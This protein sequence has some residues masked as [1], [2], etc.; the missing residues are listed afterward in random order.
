MESQAAHHVEVDLQDGALARLGCVRVADH[1]ER[2]DGGDLP[3]GEHPVHVV[4]GHDDEHR[5]K[6]QEHEGRE[7]VTAVV[8]LAAGGAGRLVLV[9]L[10][11]LH[12][13]QGVHAD[14]AAH[15]AH[16]EHHDHGEVIHVE[17][18]LE[19]V[20]GRR[21]QRSAPD[22]EEELHHGEREHGGVAER[23]GI[24]EHHAAKQQVNAHGHKITSQGQVARDGQVRWRVEKRGRERDRRGG[25]CHSRR[26]DDAIAR[27]VLPNKQQDERH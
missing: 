27:R 24:A 20:L 21:G 7:L 19:D 6:E 8:D 12:V 18:L 17:R 25:G 16:D 11:V 23:D 4:R 14:R 26:D 15:Q 3:A 10:E 2:A 13:A 1:E 5:G 9:V 22:G